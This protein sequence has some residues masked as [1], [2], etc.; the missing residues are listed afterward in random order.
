MVGKLATSILITFGISTL[1]SGI[2]YYAGY[3]FWLS[4]LTVTVIQ[5]G[6]WNLI[7]YILEWRTAIKLRD[8]EST[9]LIELNKQVINIP[10]IH[11]KTVNTVPIRFDQ[12]N[13][14]Q[15]TDCD[16]TNSVYIEVEVAAKTEIIDRPQF[17]VR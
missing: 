6:L 8:I 13:E 17:I 10:C 1:L 4:F 2:S 14:F 15:C 11:C 5:F 9:M 16:K 3:S 12:N 7:Q